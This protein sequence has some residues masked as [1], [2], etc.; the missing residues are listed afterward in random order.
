[1]LIKQISVFIENKTG[2]LAE[3]LQVLGDGGIDISALSI[4]DTK[5]FGILRLIVDKPDEA[6][7]VLK[8]KGF[9]VSITSV[10]GIGVKDEPGGLGKALEHLGRANVDIEY[11]YAFVGRS[12]GEA[13]VI[14]K[15]NNPEKAIKTLTANGIK[16]LTSNTVYKH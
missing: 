8:E 2:R 9:T 4:A 14:L 12:E 10:I 5:D 13:L 7:K 11:I 16:V 15:V 1:M 6:E 3:V